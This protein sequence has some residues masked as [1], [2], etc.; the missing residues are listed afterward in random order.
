MKPCPLLSLFT[1]FGRVFAIKCR[2]ITCP[3]LDWTKVHPD[4]RGAIMKALQP[5]LFD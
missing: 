4:V 2:T 1:G 5:S 3:E